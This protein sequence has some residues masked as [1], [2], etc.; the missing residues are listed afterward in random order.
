MGVHKEKNFYQLFETCV[1]S[2]CP[3]WGFIDQGY[4]SWNDQHNLNTATLNPEPLNL[5]TNT[6][7]FLLFDR[8]PH[9]SLIAFFGKTDTRLLVPAD[10][11][12][13]ILFNIVELAGLG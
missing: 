1:V 10:F 13:V 6:A 9:Y 3:G 4:L 11:N 7:H 5:I 12:F 2:A 8:C